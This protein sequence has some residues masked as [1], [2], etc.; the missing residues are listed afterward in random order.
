M[1]FV[2]FKED[3]PFI[4]VGIEYEVKFE[5]ELEVCI[6]D[7]TGDL[8]TLNKQSSLFK[9]IY[10]PVM[11]KAFDDVDLDAVE[12]ELVH[13]LGESFEYRYVCKDG[14][15]HI[16]GWANIEYIKEQSKEEEKESDEIDSLKEDV[17][18][19]KGQVSDILR[20]LNEKI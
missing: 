16:S 9:I 6:I 14:N 1:R 10:R 17:N 5:T 20:F 3:M 13:D 18:L 8:M 19:L 7:D 12:V 4:T 15:Y 11:V 2:K